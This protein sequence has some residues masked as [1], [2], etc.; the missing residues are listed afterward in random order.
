MALELLVRTG[1]SASKI[2]YIDCFVTEIRRGTPCEACIYS[3][4]H[5]RLIAS[6]SAKSLDPAQAIPSFKFYFI[7][8]VSLPF[9]HNMFK[10]LKLNKV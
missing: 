4:V 1:Y 5:C 9:A 7:K 2:C 6:P 3:V 8:L 10:Q